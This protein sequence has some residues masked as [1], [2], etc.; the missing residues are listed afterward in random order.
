MRKRLAGIVAALAMGIVPVAAV[1]APALASV[2]VCTAFGENWCID[3]NSLAAGTAIVNGT[4]RD[5]I[6]QDQGHKSGGLE[7]YRLVFALDMTKCVGLSANG[8][9]E[10]RDCSGGDSSFVNW[11]NDKTGNGTTFWFNT[12]Y[13]AGDCAT[14]GDQGD[15]LTSDNIG[16]DRIFCS[17]DV[18]SGDEAQWTPSPSP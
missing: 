3:A 6:V 5:I 12:R 16:G 2:H 14:S 17:G 4:G 13:P 7:V 1:Q 18:K 10:V 9:A 11:Q 8:L 15:F